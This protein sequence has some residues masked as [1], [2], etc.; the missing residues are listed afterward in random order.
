[1]ANRPAALLTGRPDEPSSPPAAQGVGLLPPQPVDQPRPGAGEAA[2]SSSLIAAVS[3]LQQ[4]DVRYQ[5]V[6]ID[7]QGGIVRL[8]GVV[9]RWEDMFELA[10]SIARL[11]G[12]ERVILQDVKTANKRR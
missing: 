5:Q 1:M 10:Q 6:Q 8:G 11:P 2:T 7:V 9:N 3:R 12:V 4:A